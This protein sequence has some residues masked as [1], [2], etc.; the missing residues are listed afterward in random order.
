[1]SKTKKLLIVEDDRFLAR[2]YALAFEPEHLS[3]ETVYDGES[4]L[5]MTNSFEPDVILLDILLPKKNGFEVLKELKANAA[6]KHIPV[7]VAS[8][9]GQEAEIAMAEKLG[10][11]AYIV[12][13]DTT[14]TEVVK[15]V[16]TALRT[17]N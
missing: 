8:N 14:I 6:T 11:T 10:A 9:L 12:K 7:I 5:P 16:I 17:P 13:S 1:M 15:K 4:V 3:L 2:S